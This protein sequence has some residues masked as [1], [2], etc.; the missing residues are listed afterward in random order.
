[1]DF[2]HCR[3]DLPILLLYNLDRQWPAPAINE[4]VELTNQL[5][6]ALQEIGHPT[7]IVG[8]ENDEIHHLLSGY[9]PDQH[10]IFN[11][12]EEIPGLPRSA[13]RVAARLEESGF[14]FT[15]AD[16]KALAASQDK[17]WIKRRLSELKIATPRWEVSG[18]PSPVAWG[19]FPAIVKPVFEH[20]SFGIT[21]EAVVHDT[22][23]MKQRIEYI[24]DTFRQPAI[25][26]DF[27]DGRE[28]HVGVIGNGRLRVLPAAEM[29]FSAFP[30]PS[31]RLCTYASKFEPQSADYQLIGL[32]LPAP[33]NKAEQEAL[34]AASL[35]AYRAAACRDYAR[36]D[37]RLRD[38]VFYV[39]DVNP[40]ADIS[41]DASL[42]LAAE[43]A[44]LSYGQLG[45]Y[46]VNLA[47]QRLP[48]CHLK[49]AM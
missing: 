12:C 26:E 44:G 18:S 13:A 6:R 24:L 3:T 25:V 30:E 39:L 21:H 16:S 14:V 19:I 35:A 27:I 31:G 15:G 23:Q 22:N 41:P 11:W 49:G 17:R 20:C 9:R 33:L 1:M 29:D 7:E 46:L 34:E 48:N 28:F 38:G 10:I 5:S 8:V 40:N 43:S 37:I 45:S 42:A 4:V 32:K 47:A 2:Q 36:M